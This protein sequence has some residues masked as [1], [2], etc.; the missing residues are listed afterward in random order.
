MNVPEITVPDVNVNLPDFPDYTDLLGKIINLLESFFV[1]DA[2]MILAH[3]DALKDLWLL[4]L[5]FLE[6]L[7]TLFGAFNFGDSY[8]YP[9]I[10]IKTPSILVGYYDSDYI[11]L[12]DFADYSKYVLWARNLVRAML[13][14]TFGLSVFKHF[15]TSLHVG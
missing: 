9:V 4:H 1:I 8:S 2:D 15:R 11:V 3:A 13:W 12:L 14:F 7:Q 5:P 10:K 6:Q